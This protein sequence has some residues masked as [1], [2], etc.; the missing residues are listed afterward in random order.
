MKKK[1]LIFVVSTILYFTI[2]SPFYFPDCISYDYKP[3]QRA[4]FD[5]T[6]EIFAHISIF[7]ILVVFFN[8]IYNFVRKTLE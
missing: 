3:E 4:V 6:W 8:G 2:I 1:I 5:P 7:I